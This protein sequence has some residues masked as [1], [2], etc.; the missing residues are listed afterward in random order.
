MIPQMWFICLPSFL[1]FLQILGL[2]L[3]LETKSYLKGAQVSADLLCHKKIGNTRHFWGIVIK[4]SHPERL[5]RYHDDIYFLRRK[6]MFSTQLFSML[7]N[8]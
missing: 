6:K 1:L 3:T 4:M 2:F 7:S 5:H 8:T